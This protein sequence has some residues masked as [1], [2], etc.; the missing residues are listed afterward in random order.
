MCTQGVYEIRVNQVTAGTGAY[1]ISVDGSAF[2]SIPPLPY[3]VSGLNSGSHTIIIQANGCTDTET[4]II[5][6][7]LVATPAITALP[8]CANNDGV[9]YGG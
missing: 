9:N 7:P 2:T 4:I 8:S 6:E 5:D 3:I 1:S